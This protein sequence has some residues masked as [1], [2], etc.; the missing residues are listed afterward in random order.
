MASETRYV[1]KVD[2]SSENQLELWLYA[3]FR[4]EYNGRSDALC[5]DQYLSVLGFYKTN[6]VELQT[7]APPPHRL[8]KVMAE[9][10]EVSDLCISP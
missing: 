5:H 3:P 9:L 8:P 7:A 10:P 6:V 1:L 4:E 2:Y